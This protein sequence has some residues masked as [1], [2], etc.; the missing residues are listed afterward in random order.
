MKK[1]ILL[2]NQS[3]VSIFSNPNY[4]MKQRKVYTPLRLSTNGGIL[5][6]SKKA[7][8]PGF[9]EVW[10]NSDVYQLKL[11]RNIVMVDG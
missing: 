8:V 1:W 7:E 10:Y 11:E 4:V 9:G 3:N 5:N 2:D 6:T